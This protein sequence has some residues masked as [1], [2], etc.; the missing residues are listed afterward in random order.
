MK[1]YVA[2]ASFAFAILAFAAVW[3]GGLNQDEGWYLYAAQLVGE[4]KML[5]RDFFYTQGP[6]MPIIYAPFA[7]IWRNAGLLG[8]RIFT[9]V[10]GLAGMLFAAALARTVAPEGKRGLA[11]V[12]TFLMLGCNLYHIYYTA[13]PKTYA[14]AALFVM[15]GYYLMACAFTERGRRFSVALLFTSGLSLAFASG[16]RISLGALLAVCGFGLLLSFRTCRWSFLWFGLGGMLG[17]LAIYGPFVFDQQAFAG[18][19]AAQKYHAAR[20]GFD[21]VFTV[22][23]FSRLVRWYLPVFVLFGLG[24]F[25][26]VVSRRRLSEAVGLV[27][28]LA[29]WGF[30]VVLTV[31][32]LAPFPYEDYQVPIMGLLSVFVS[33]LCTTLVTSHDEAVHPVVRQ[34]HLLPLLALGLTWA[35]S[36]GSP[37]LEGWMTNG[38]DRF[39]SRKKAKCELKQLQDAAA[40]IESVDPGGKMLLTQDLYLAVETGRKVP[41]G[42]EMGPFSMLSDEAWMKLLSSSPCEV[43]A[44]SGYSFC[45]N[46]PVCDERP[47]DRQMAYWTA[48]K[49]D[50]KLVCQ[51]EDFGQNATTLL[52]LKKKATK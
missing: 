44:L 29:L 43:A 11:G 35:C 1:V 19:C 39:W 51:V 8:A 34:V 23:S 25:G 42:L 5:Y 30:L 31:Q 9:C 7:W 47:I 2:L 13:I 15:M 32:M 14:L 41:E 16:T 46:P 52:V 4:G 28:R 33:V 22:G 24:V 37:L 27:P 26:L 12:L 18:L 17:L 50:Y 3:L 49:N 40:V 38:Q 6:A 21:P 36:F 20:G 48:L 10:L 45:I